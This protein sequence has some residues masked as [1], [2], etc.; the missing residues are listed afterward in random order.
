[1]RPPEA[2]DR[3]KVLIATEALDGG[4]L[5]HLSYLVEH[6][7]RD[8]FDVHLAVS[9]ERAVHVRDRV[10]AWREAGCPVHEVPMCRDLLPHRDLAAF[11]SLLTLC[12]RERYD[13]VH[14][15]CAKAG[16]LGRLAARM[17]G[18]KTVHTPHTFPFDR[19][20]RRWA[21]AF[22][23]ALERR[24]AGWTDCMVLLSRYQANIVVRRRLLPTGRWTVIANGID[25]GG[26]GRPDRR[27]ARRVL[28]LPA[29]G[30]VVVAMGRL[31]RQKGQDTLLEA[32]ALAKRQADAGLRVLLVGAGLLEEKLKAHVAARGLGDV[33]SLPGAT[34]HPDLYYA[35]ADLVAMPS[36]FEGM[37]YVMLEARAA[38]R[39]VAASLCSGMEEFVRH[40]RDGLL[41]APGNADA[42]ART[43]LGA[44]RRPE[45]LRAIGERGRRSLRPEWEARVSV[46]RLAGLYERL[47]AQ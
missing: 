15:H 6:L 34:R 14:T 9:A 32:V 26:P 1:M 17:S 20:G 23:L 2:R 24:A 40:G 16:F 45:E 21:E 10:N 4:V 31:C 30:T 19:G 12:R 25:L 38:G 35:A 18:A 29:G 13:V 28:G 27:T 46:G 37:P 44:C 42:W 33:V 39:P 43:L 3:P 7:P 22:Y 11:L 41:V 47:S 36:Q 5:R 8:R